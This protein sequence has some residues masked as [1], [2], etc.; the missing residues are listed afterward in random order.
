MGAWHMVRIWCVVSNCMVLN[1]FVQRKLLKYNTCKWAELHFEVPSILIID[2]LHELQGIRGFGEQVL[3]QALGKDFKKDYYEV[4][5]VLHSNWLGVFGVQVSDMYIDRL[6]DAQDD[7]KLQRKHDAVMES[8]LGNP[9]SRNTQMNSFIIWF[10]VNK[11]SAIRDYML[12][13]IQKEC[14]LGCPHEPFTKNAGESINVILKN[15]LDYQYFKEYR[16]KVGY[17]DRQKGKLLQLLES[18]Q[19]QRLF[20]ATVNK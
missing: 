8:W 18:P 3:A 13:P 16:L 5:A 19:K 12:W 7:D 9:V 15:K 14:G 10:D 17:F 6:V 20:L 2:F 11:L 4:S 1:K